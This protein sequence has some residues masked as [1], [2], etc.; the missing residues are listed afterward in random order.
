MHGIPF[1]SEFYTFQS[2]PSALWA[3]IPSLHKSLESAFSFR[4]VYTKKTSA[5]KSVQ[6]ATNSP[7]SMLWTAIIEIF[8]CFSVGL[9]HKS[10]IKGPNLQ[11]RTWPSSQDVIIPLKLIIQSQNAYIS[12]PH[13]CQIQNLALQDN[14]VMWMLP[15]PQVFSRH[16]TVHDKKNML[17]INDISFEV[18][19][20][21]WGG[22]LPPMTK[23]TS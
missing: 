2:F 16:S 23:S 6:S 22:S 17:I 14:R 18:P 11:N 20:P 15:C 12:T 7:R 21:Q 1:P 9:S 10:L 5:G 8:V 13:K 4:R 3:H 19:E